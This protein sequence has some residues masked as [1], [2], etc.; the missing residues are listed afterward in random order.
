MGHG[1]SFATG[2]ALA[3]KLDKR[4][5]RVYCLMGDGELAEG[6]NWEAAMTAAHYSLDNLIGIIDR[7]RLQITGNTENVVKLEPLIDKWVAFGWEAIEVDSHDVEELKHM[8]SGLPR[9]SGKPSMVIA[10]TVK[11]KG[12]SFAE[13]KAEWHHK[14]PT[15]DQHALLMGEIDA[16][17][18]ETPEDRS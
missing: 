8:L 2:L 10:N 15:A 11:G 18:A 13:G 12:V 7:N 1:L 6:S 4:S 16:R 3:A 17:S 9:A 5:S 14:V